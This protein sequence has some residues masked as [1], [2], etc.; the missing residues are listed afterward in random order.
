MELDAALTY[1]QLWHSPIGDILLTSD[2]QA[3]TGLYV[4]S[5]RHAPQIQKHWQPAGTRLAHV[6]QQLDEYFKGRRT[7][8]DVVTR[9]RGTAF[10]QQVWAA[11]CAIPYGETRSYGTLA[12]RIGNP[13]ASRAVGLAN[14]RNPISIIVPCHRVIGAS[15]SLV[16][17]GGGLAAK[18]FL[19]DLEGSSKN[20]LSIAELA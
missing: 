5:K 7:E 4:A 16:G 2:G 8:F 9:P 20:L 18:R 17:Y 3:L 15:G 12:K 19:L 6:I 10:Q 14:G 11:L 13:L 1:Y